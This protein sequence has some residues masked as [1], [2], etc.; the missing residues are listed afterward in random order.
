[1]KYRSRRN[2]I[3]RRIILIAAALLLL[4]LLIVLYCSV[5]D[6]LLSAT[7]ETMRARTATAVNE[8]VFETLADSVRYDD[9]VTVERDA[10]GEIRAIFANA[11]EINRIAR[12]TAYLAQKKL[13]AMGE[14]GI[15]LPLGAF[16]GIDALAGFGPSVR[17]RLIP[18]AVVTCRFASEFT[19]AGI[20][21]TRHAVF[22]EV[23]A[24]I[25]VV[26]PGRTQNFSTSSEVLIAESV[27]VGDVPQVYL[28]GDIFGAVSRAGGG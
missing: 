25:S 6:I 5:T 15:A 18:V 10:Q 23:T 12:D 7:Q 21:Q 24:E 3:L 9:L 16:S 13:Q 28:Q 1:M 26:L 2:R 27:L 19:Q 14:E 4:T 17:I 8:A 22:L 20:N 11:Y